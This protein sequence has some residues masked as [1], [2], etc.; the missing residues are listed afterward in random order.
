VDERRRNSKPM[1]ITNAA[2]SRREQIHKREVRYVLMMLI[3]AVCIIV[4][5]VLVYNHV[6]LLGLW[7]PILI[8]GML[9]IPWLA[10]ILANDRAPKEQ[11]RLSGKFR[12]RPAAP[13][14]SQRALVSSDEPVREPRTIDADED[15]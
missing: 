3:R 12:R 13:A 14:P 4:A 8:F 7:I 6:P 11:Y 15:D 10:V 5:T 1:R 2:P 9:A